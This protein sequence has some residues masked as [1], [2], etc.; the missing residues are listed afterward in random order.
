MQRA[1]GLPGGRRHVTLA[2]RFA[3]CC[4]RRSFVR[5]AVSDC[6]PVGPRPHGRRSR[7]PGSLLRCVPCWTATVS[8]ATA[9]GCGRPAC[10]WRRW[11]RSTSPPAPRPGSRSSASSGA[12]RCRRRAGRG[13]TRR[14]WRACSRGW[15]RSWTA[16]R[17]IDPEPRPD[18]QRPPA[19]SR[20]I[21]ERDSRSAGA[22]RRCD[23][24]AAG[25]QRGRT[26]FRQHRRHAVGFADPAGPL[27]VGGAQAE[28]ACGRDFRRARPHD[29]R[30]PGLAGAGRLSR[31]GSAVRIAGRRRHSTSLSGRRRVRHRR[32]AVPPALRR[33]HRAR[34]AARGRDPVGWRADSLPRSS[35]AKRPAGPRRPD[36]SETFSGV[37]RGSSTPGTPT[38]ASRCGC[39]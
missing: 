35:A 8:V 39:R 25:R 36:S 38:P 9:T 12:G 13:P 28:P 14:S 4:W 3:G 2:L 16:P 5:P 29:R 30:I 18:G 27:S 34:L 11:M 10:R 22:G 20:R 6:Q 33:D 7:R 19:Q 1:G 23:V 37:R 17:R 32:P 31:R 26:R 21:P 15:K 24:A